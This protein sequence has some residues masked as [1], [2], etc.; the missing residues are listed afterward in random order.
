MRN[1]YFDLLNPIGVFD[2]DF[3]FLTTG[4]T[5]GYSP[6]TTSWFDII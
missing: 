3:I 4:F 2:M 6:L 5:C 1:I